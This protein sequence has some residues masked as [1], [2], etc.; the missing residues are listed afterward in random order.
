MFFVFNNVSFRL[1]LDD[2]AIFFLFLTT[3]FPDKKKE[4]RGI[5]SPPIFQL[6]QLVKVG[7]SSLRI[8]NVAHRLFVVSVNVG[9]NTESLLRNSKLH[10]LVPH[11]AEFHFRSPS[12]GFLLTPI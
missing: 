1:A 7:I 9:D 2:G 12:V 4:K 10:K 6:V 3:D 11:L 5:S 8:E